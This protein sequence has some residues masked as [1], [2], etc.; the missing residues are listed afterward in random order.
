MDNQ[1]NSR[2]ALKIVFILSLLLVW[3]DMLELYFSYTHLKDTAE[4]F[5]PHIFEQCIKYHLI[6]QM[7]F[8]VF[9]TFAGISACIMSLGLLINYEFF[10]IKVLD[11]FLQYNYFIFG[12]YLIASC[13]LGFYYFND[14]AY[15][16][17]PNQLS[18][19]YINFSTVLAM[20]IC[21]FISF[22]I[23]FG[24]SVY[25]SFKML[26]NSIRFTN[27]GSVILGRIFWRYVFNRSRET[28]HIDQS[29]E[30]SINYHQGEHRMM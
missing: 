23:T 4:R 7:F 25:W 10:A 12:P 3:M 2:V 24:Y 26:L 6:S 28:I 9:A 19:K 16:C 30:N 11:T 14:V 22:V 1:D 20:M 29:E 8:T 21:L 5:D 18:R 13:L 17:D 15:N 27:E